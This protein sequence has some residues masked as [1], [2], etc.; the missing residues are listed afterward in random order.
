MISNGLC[1]SVNASDDRLVTYLDIFAFTVSPHCNRFL[2][3]NASVIA[4]VSRAVS[5][6][7]EMDRPAGTAANFRSWFLQSICIVYGDV[8]N[9]RLVCSGHNLCAVVEDDNDG[10]GIEFRNNEGRCDI[11]SFS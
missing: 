7:N 10:V 9:S 1:I 6:S 11:E 8:G 5:C 2:Y 3:F 4:V